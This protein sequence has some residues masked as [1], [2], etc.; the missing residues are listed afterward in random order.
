MSVR[1]MQLQLEEAGWTFQR[2]SQRT[3]KWKR[4]TSNS[5]QFARAIMWAWEQEWGRHER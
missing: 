4:I 2:R 3:G 1:E 5:R